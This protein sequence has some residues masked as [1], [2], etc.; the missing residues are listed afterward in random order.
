MVISSPTQS[1][2]QNHR[3]QAMTGTH[4]RERLQLL[5][6]ETYLASS[7]LGLYTL[8]VTQ[9]AGSAKTQLTSFRTLTL[10]ALTHSNYRHLGHIVATASLSLEK[11]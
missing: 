2:I 4:L 11:K 10:Q 6:G 9:T 1:L 5:I 8:W 7:A 3:T